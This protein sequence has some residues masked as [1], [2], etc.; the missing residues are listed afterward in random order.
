MDYTYAL[1]KNE[2]LAPPGQNSQENSISE[3]NQRYPSAAGRCH[4]RHR[5]TEWSSGWPCCWL[6]LA[7]VG[8]KRLPNSR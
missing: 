3:C 7:V 2:F 6:L 4:G 1:D 5:T 8:G